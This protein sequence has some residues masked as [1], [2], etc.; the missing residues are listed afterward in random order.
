MLHR[1]LASRAP[2][3]Q[4]A[5]PA[6]AESRRRKQKAERRRQQ[7]KNERLQAA[8]RRISSSPAAAAAAA[9]QHNASAR[10]A[11]LL[12]VVVVMVVV[13]GWIWRRGCLCFCGRSSSSVYVRWWSV[14]RV[15]TGLRSL[16]LSFAFPFTRKLQPLVG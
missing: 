12:V 13:V 5:Q 7:P 11:E 6:E 4:G 8:L 3:Q 10:E 15:C 16:S 2:S 14:G 9:R 1:A